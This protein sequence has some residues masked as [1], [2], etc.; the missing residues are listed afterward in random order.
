MGSIDKLPELMSF[1]RQLVTG[2]GPV[3]IYSHCEVGEA[4]ALN[5]IMPFPQRAC[6]L[7]ST[8]TVLIASSAHTHTHTPQYTQTPHTLHTSH[9]TP[10]TPHTSHL[11]PH[12]SHPTPHTTHPTHHT[13]THRRVLIARERSVDPTTSSSST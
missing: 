10:R 11:T 9:L 7:Y 13:H 3:L 4:V 1:F 6:I 12:T 8:H 2:P 5:M